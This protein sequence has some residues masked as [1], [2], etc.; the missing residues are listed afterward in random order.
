MPVR[1][2]TFEEETSINNLDDAM[3]EWIEVNVHSVSGTVISVQYQAV[4][5]QESVKYTAL[6]TYED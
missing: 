3:N 2:K 4:Y 6:V 1:V 5:D